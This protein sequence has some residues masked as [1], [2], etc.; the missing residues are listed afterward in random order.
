MNTAVALSDELQMLRDSISVKLARNVRQGYEKDQHTRG[1]Y[2]DGV[3]LNVERNRLLTESYKVTEG[4]PMVLRRAKALSHILRNMSIFIVPNSRIVGHSG[5]TPDDLYY[6]IE[7]NWQSPWRALNSDDA[8][9]LLDDE[10]RAEM[11]EIVEYWKGK[12][13]SDI[14]KEAFKGDLEKFF[15]Y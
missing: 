5:S 11:K 3:K 15:K 10:S 4:E 2:R 7:I 13:L 14:R 12:T 6:P 9:N 1:M 8:R